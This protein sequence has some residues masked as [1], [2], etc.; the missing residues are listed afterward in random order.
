MLRRLSIFLRSDEEAAF[1]SG[2][3]QAR[4]WPR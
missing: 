4:A 2:M 1:S 3:D